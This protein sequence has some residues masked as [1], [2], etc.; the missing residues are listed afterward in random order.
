LYNGRKQHESLQTRTGARNGGVEHLRHG[1]AGRGVLLDLAR[2]DASGALPTDSVFGVEE[3]ER[4][5]AGQ[6]V[7]LN[8]GD[9]VFIRTGRDVLES[10]GRYKFEHDGGPGLSLEGL[11]WLAE[12][13]IALLGSDATTD[14]VPSAYAGWTNPIHV[15]AIVG[16]GMCLIDNAYLE[17]LARAC[18]EDH[19]WS[20]FLLI[21]PLP[22]KYTT[23]SPVNP[24]AIF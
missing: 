8:E 4:C 3:L 6:N 14:R 23:G 10:R 13:N 12:R 2:Q 11:A 1:I 20:F 24:I 16:M 22:L 17:D 19:R 7:Q 18:E 21:A 9:L 5:A 15:V